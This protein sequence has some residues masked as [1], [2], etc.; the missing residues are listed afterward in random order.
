MKRFPSLKPQ[1]QADKSGLSSCDQKKRTNLD[2]HPVITEKY[3][4]ENDV[5]MELLIKR[6]WWSPQQDITGNTNNHGPLVAEPE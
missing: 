1:Q 4:H 6:F 3:I 5:P 2:Y